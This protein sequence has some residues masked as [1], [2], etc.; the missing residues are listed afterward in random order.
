[1]APLLD[2]F[3][4]YGT[5][6]FRNGEAEYLKASPEIVKKSKD[7]LGTVTPL[8]TYTVIAP[9]DRIESD[10]GVKAIICFGNGEQ[11]RNLASMVHYRS[12]D[13]FNAVRA[14]WGPTC[15]TLLTYP[16]GVAEKAPLDSAYLGPT[17]PTGNRW[18]PEGWMA[19]GI[20][21]K[22]AI[23]IC[24]DLDNAFVTKR[25]HVAYPEVHESLQKIV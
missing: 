25:P 15:A 23:S 18:F 14:A 12:I 24:E 8:G 22:L 1:M 16:A 9:C 17:D 5:K 10:P 11:I 20:P 2:Y 4:S 7:A 3:V 19:L 6:E 21:I 13:T